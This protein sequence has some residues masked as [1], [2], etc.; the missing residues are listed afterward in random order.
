MV[1]ESAACL[2]RPSNEHR[3]LVLERPEPLTDF[4]AR[5]GQAAQEWFADWLVR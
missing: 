5:E 1:E 2:A 4:R 3:H